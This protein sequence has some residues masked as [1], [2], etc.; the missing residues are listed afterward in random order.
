MAL[1][2][3]MMAAI[4][5]ALT[6]EAATDPND[7]AAMHAFAKA[8]G[9]DSAL[10]WS[11]TSDPC[12]QWPKV[13]CQGDRV[14][15]IQIGNISNL[16][17]TVPPEVGNLTSLQRLELQ[18]V[19]LTGPLPS[20]KGL[21]LLNVLLLN[22]NKFSS[23]PPDFF[24]GLSAIT[25]VNIDRNPF[26]SWAIPT[27]LKECSSLLNFSANDANVTGGVPDFFASAFPALNHLGLANNL[28]GGQIPESFASSGMKSLWLNGAG[29]SGGVHVIADMTNLIE[30]FLQSNSLTGP[31][32]DFSRLN[33]LQQLNLRDNQITGIVPK[34]LT[35][36]KSLQTVVLTNNLL[37]GPVPVFGKGVNLD[38]L[39][40]RES[41]CHDSSDECDP[42]VTVL[43]SIASS[44]RYPV[45]FAQN[46]KG[47]DPC[48]NWIGISCD[49]SGNIIVVNFQKMNLS[50]VI[51]P[52]FMSLGSLQKLI[53]SNNNLTGTIPSG[54][55][56]LK[57]L[58]LLD[59]SNN[60]IFGQV[61]SFSSNIVVNTYGNPNIGKDMRGPPGRSAPGS[62]PDSSS[63]GKSNAGVIV[64]CVIAG[65]FVIVIAGSLY[66]FYRKRKEA[67]LDKIQTHG[68]VIHPRHSGSDAEL[69]KITVAVNENE[70]TSN[71]GSG[72][73]NFQVVEPVN[74][75]ISINVLRA[76]TDNF[77]E[78]KILGRGGFGTVYKGE[79]DDG[80][81]IA[82]KRMESGGALSSKGLKEFKSEIS[83]LTKVRHRHLV[84]LLGYCLEENER[85]LVY[86]YMPQG[87]LSDHLFDWEVAVMKP[88]EWKMRLC[89][90]LDVA[91]GVEYLHS[92]MNE[93]FVHRDLKPSNILLANDMRAKVADFGLVRLAP[94]GKQYSLAT[95]LAGTFGYVAPE[96]AEMGRVTTKSDVF[97]FGVILMELI[98]GRKALDQSRPSDST[99]L[100]TWFRK[101]QI[102]SEFT[103]ALDPAI[104][105]NDDEISLSVNIVS[106][107]AFHCCARDPQQR[108]DMSHVVSILCPLAEK[109][110]PSQNLDDEYGIET[111]KSL[112]Q[113][114]KE[115]GI[116]SNIM[117]AGSLKRN[118][119][120]SMY[121]NTQDSVPPNPRDLPQAR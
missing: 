54:L 73:V 65:I 31:L 49:Q 71:T 47:N 79:L 103:K 45:K 36:L 115:W 37:Q 13:K 111:S 89:I 60:T 75:V 84:S 78:D 77:S 35:E 83:V 91:R 51:S 42:R 61:P 33:S 121:H 99:H 82:V 17:G 55:V 70:T 53:L 120:G 29:L 80:T 109:W 59:V 119:M 64:G 30:V 11:P 14:S 58:K 50:G 18:Y 114:L 2:P 22:D 107:L 46:W 98:T 7:A 34:S 74:L 57:A 40:D 66:F 90:A 112:P 118:T 117:N 23:I 56:N 48:A 4:L 76:V 108:P 20:L 69:L 21:V 26:S 63:G 16:S 3:F 67:K 9:A 87:T 27:T 41:F 5:L 110:K 100:I 25:V 85:M 94:E 86:E 10:N 24:D 105:L 93:S 38:L 106:D 12:T 97:S 95:T 72:R 92:L 81:M 116:G 39:P 62:S 88:L 101:M 104:D 52:D 6:A 113:V 28:L 32:P 43:L 19:G 96:Y 102:N 15:I 1:L 8:I 68:M 44:F